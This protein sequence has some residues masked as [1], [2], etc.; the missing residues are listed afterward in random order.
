MALKVLTGFLV[1]IV[2]CLA[3]GLLRLCF[4]EARRYIKAFF[5]AEDEEENLTNEEK[6]RRYL[7]KK[8]RELAKER[9]AAQIRQKDAGTQAEYQNPV[10]IIG[11]MEPIGR[12]TRYVMSEKRSRLIGVKPSTLQNGFWQMLVSMKGMYQGKHRGRSR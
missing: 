7:E 4:N 5:S 9:A 12:W 10:R 11:L 3:F 1:F 6:H 2:V 8:H